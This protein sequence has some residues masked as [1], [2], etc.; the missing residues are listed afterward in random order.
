MAKTRRQRA[1]EHPGM[2][3]KGVRDPRRRPQGPALTDEQRAAATVFA[4][5][6]G[7]APHE[8]R[9]LETASDEDRQKVAMA[10]VAARRAM[11][12]LPKQKKGKKNVEDKREEIRE[13]EREIA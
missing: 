2:P 13:S 11:G 3:K 7:K 4:R 6:G 5:I 10:G 12:L 8:T 9:G 1:A